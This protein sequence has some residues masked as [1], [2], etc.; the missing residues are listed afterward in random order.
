MLPSITFLNQVSIDHAIVNTN[1]NLS[2]EMISFSRSGQIYLFNKKRMQLVLTSDLPFLDRMRYSIFR[3]HD[4]S[5]DRPRANVGANHSGMAYFGRLMSSKGQ[6][7]R[8]LHTSRRRR[9]NAASQSDRSWTPC[10][11]LG[12]LRTLA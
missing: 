5:G 1:A 3:Q 12:L 6:T 11:C 2:H 9:S 8:R 7:E 4:S 10:S